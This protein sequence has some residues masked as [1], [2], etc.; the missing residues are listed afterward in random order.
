M[1][2]EL[3]EYSGHL[4]PP[5]DLEGQRVLVA[6]AH[7]VGCRRAHFEAGGC[8]GQHCL[9]PVRALHTHVHLGAALLHEHS[10][11]ADDR[12]P[13]CNSDG[14]ECG[15]GPNSARARRHRCDAR[16]QLVR[17]I[18]GELERSRL[19]GAAD[20]QQLAGH[21]P[22][23][24]ASWRPRGELHEPRAPRSSARHCL[25][26]FDARSLLA[27]HQEQTLRIQLGQAA[28]PE[29]DQASARQFPDARLH[30][31]DHSTFERVMV[32]ADPT[33][34][35]LVRFGERERC[36]RRAV[37]GPALNENKTLA[38]EEASGAT[39][40]TCSPPGIPGG[41]ITDNLAT[42]SVTTKSCTVR[43]VPRTEAT[44]VSAF[45]TTKLATETMTVDPAS[46]VPWLG[47]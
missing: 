11:A 40:I 25:E 31:L 32:G 14:D 13:V 2:R 20:H 27:E 4:G 12:R 26:G 3:R 21:W 41:T 9:R 5:S 17:P 43:L 18:V 6:R 19:R 44:R 30:E 39:E 15:V 45:S 29:L 47:S 35:Q 23:E 1:R 34:A 24:Q 33:L 10:L 22:D 7:D 8:K 28:D 36:Q 16:L 42:C 38:G 37:D 46:V